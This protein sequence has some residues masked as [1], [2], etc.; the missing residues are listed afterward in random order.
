MSHLEARRLDRLAFCR[1]AVHVGDEIDH[2]AAHD[3]DPRR[4]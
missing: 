4:A 2:V 3:G 1:H